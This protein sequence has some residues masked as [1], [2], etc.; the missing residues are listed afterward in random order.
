MKTL[1]VKVKDD[2]TM[3]L[4]TALSKQLGLEPKVLSDKKREDIALIH[5][6]DEAMKGKKLPVS[7]A[8]RILDTLSR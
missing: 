4:L 5:A 3:K 1:V 8:Y 2:S 7:S 6:I